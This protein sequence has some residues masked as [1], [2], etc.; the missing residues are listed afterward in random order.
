MA[1]WPLHSD[2]SQITGVTQAIGF[3]IDHMAPGGSNRNNGRKYQFD[4]SQIINQ[5]RC[6]D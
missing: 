4:L 1:E 6:S 2:S 3:V 5:S